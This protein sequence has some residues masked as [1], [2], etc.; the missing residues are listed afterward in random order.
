MPSHTWQLLAM[1]SPHGAS[2]G[3]SRLTER[4]ARKISVDSVKSASGD[5]VRELVRSSQ[6]CRVCGLVRD[7]EQDSV[8]ELA[9]L[10]IKDDFRSQYY[11]SQGVCLRHLAM[12]LDAVGSDDIRSFLLTVASER[13]EEDSEDMRSFALKQE[14]RR[15]AL[16][17]RNEEDAY[18][19]AVI[20]MVGER[21]LCV[22]WRE[23]G[24]I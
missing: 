3:V 15:R 12:L 24:E 5:A 16:E 14:S 23:D 2:V 13:F 4:I 9:D 20:R 8:H 18:R 19:R 1:C 17:N 11:G 6:N 7:W 10:L 22:P 21:S